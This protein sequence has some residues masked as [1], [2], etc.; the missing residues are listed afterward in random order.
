MGPQVTSWIKNR[1]YMLILKQLMRPPLIDFKGCHCYYLKD[2]SGTIYESSYT[3]PIMYNAYFMKYKD[4]M[5]LLY[6]YRFA[7]SL[8][9][10]ALD[11]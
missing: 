8:E 10:N 1:L 11:V 6:N 7:G 2:H 4:F 5:I 9:L 3:L